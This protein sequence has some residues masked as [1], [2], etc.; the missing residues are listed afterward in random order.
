MDTKREQLIAA[1]AYELWEEEGRPQGAH[2][3]HWLQASREVEA[4][5]RKKSGGRPAVKPTTATAAKAKPAAAKAKTAVK[6]KLKAAAEA[7]RAP[8][9]RAARPARAGDAA[10]PSTGRAKRS[11]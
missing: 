10:K 8:T 11:D 7:T 6:P 3:R 4:A 1:R 5:A 9:K 2:E